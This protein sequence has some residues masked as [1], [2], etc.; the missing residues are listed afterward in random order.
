MHLFRRHGFAGTSAEQLVQGL[1]VSRHAIYSEFGSKQ[2]L[3]EEALARYDAEVVGRSFG[4]LETPEAGV[5]EVRAL[6]AFYG[7]AGD[8]PAAGRGCLLCNTAV[9]F[10]PDDIGG[11]GFVERYFARLSAAFTNAIGNAVAR[12]ELPPTVDPDAEAHFF[13][14]TVLGMFVMIRAEAPVTAL[15]HSAQAAIRHL[16]GLRG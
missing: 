10:G 6:F 13:T 8:G 4:P 7:S 11:A 5:D 1:G 12:G 15:H 16:E 3:F 9:E 14:A 2:G